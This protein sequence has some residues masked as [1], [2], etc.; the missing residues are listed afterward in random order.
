MTELLLAAMIM[1]E[2]GGNVNVIGRNGE[3]GPLQIQ[4]RVVQEV[5]RAYQTNY[6]F[7]RDVIHTLTAKRIAKLYMY[8]CSCQYKKRTGRWPDTR[9]QLA[10][11]NGGPFGE[12]KWRA[13]R[14]AAKVLKQAY[15]RTSHGKNG[16]VRV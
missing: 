3:R 9:T 13:K 15:R 10:F 12:K 8:H 16:K 4:A 2:S 1:V 6:Q 5:N 7:P 11:W 14:Y